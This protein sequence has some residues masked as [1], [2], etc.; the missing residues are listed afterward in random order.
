M[1]LQL[2]LEIAVNEAKGMCRRDSHIYFRMHMMMICATLGVVIFVSTNQSSQAQLDLSKKVQ[3]STS[4]VADKATPE[5]LSLQEQHRE[6][7]AQRR[8]LEEERRRQIEEERRRKQ[9]R[10]EFEEERRRREDVLRA[11]PELPPEQPPSADE[12]R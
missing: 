9:E 10:R 7:L 8:E 3:K 5:P 11:P 2:M 1:V 6:R 12:R 4:T